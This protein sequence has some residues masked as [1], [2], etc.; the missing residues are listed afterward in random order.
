MNWML[1]VAISWLFLGL[2]QGLRDAFAHV[3]QLKDVRAHLW[4]CA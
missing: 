3:R 1:F 4:I 2:E